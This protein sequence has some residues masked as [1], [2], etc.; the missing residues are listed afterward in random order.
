MKSKDKGINPPKE[1]RL[2]AG[3]EMWIKNSHGEWEP[4]IYKTD[5]PWH[6]NVFALNTAF[7]TRHLRN[8]KDD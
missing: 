1:D 3:R 5:D 4:W 2:Y 7:T 8:T 6:G